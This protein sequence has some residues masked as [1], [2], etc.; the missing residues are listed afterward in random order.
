MAAKRP[1]LSVTHSGIALDWHPIKNGSVLLE[2][3][4]AHSK[5][6]AWWLCHNNGEHE[7]QQRID[8]RIKQGECGACALE[9]RSLVVLFP[10]IAKQWDD[11][12]NGEL[13][14]NMIKGQSSKKVWW[15]CPLNSKHQWSAT[16]ANRTVLRQGCPYFKGKRVD[17]TNSLAAL[18]Q[19]LVK[20]WHPPFSFNALNYVC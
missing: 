2:D 3:F 17:D 20:E 15:Q 16:V 6:I 19:Y 5:F 7:W 1:S 18:R 11:K 13:R 4:T 8:Q 12:R 9:R 14:P 10:E